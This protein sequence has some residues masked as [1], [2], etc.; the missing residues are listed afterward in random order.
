MMTSLFSALEN[1][2]F[3]CG[4]VAP[5][6]LA[7]LAAQGFAWVVNHRP[8]GEDFG[9][10]VS[11]TLAEAAT[12][13]GLSYAHIPVRGVPDLEAVEGTAR[14]LAERE[15]KAKVL[16]F[17][18]SGMRSAACWALARRLDGADPARLRETAASAGYDLSRLPL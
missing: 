16:M 1:E 8:D 5:G 6:D 9:Q 14:V 18:R 15:D 10:P 7:G 17:C 2:V 13:A 3:V 12:A 11:A 4:Q